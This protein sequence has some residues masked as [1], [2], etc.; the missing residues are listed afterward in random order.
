MRENLKVILTMG[1]MSSV[2]KYLAIH[3][4]LTISIILY[5]F[6]IKKDL[7][8][9]ACIFIVGLVILFVIFVAAPK[10]FW[11]SKYLKNNYKEIYTRRSFGR[12][13][14]DIL[15]IKESDLKTITDAKVIKFVRELKVAHKTVFITTLLC[16]LLLAIRSY[17]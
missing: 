16:I 2:R 6:F 8:Q 10:S 11:L 12:K 13:Y 5:I 17:M 9:Y 1:K 7:I 4:L 3:I 14:V 15:S